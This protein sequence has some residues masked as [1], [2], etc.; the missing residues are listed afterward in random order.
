LVATLNMKN[1]YL[2]IAFLLFVACGRNQP[3]LTPEANKQQPTVAVGPEAI[4]DKPGAGESAGLT[5]ADLE[6]KVFQMG[7]ISLFTDSCAFYFACDCCAGD[8]VF[9]ADKTFYTINHCMSDKSLA[10][11]IYS[12]QNDKLT[13][14]FNG[15]CVSKNY[16]WANE[17]DTAAVDYFMTDTIV[18][19]W[20]FTYTATWCNNKIKLTRSDNK[21][22]GI[23]TKA[24]Y[25][26]YMDVLKKEGFA[27]RLKKIGNPASN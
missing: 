24:S 9:N 10:A 22:I 23:L 19:P 8:L 21:D 15:I 5:Y 7:S 18:S 11:G 2:L 17:T 6:G 12:L 16:N 14:S 25:A 1:L 3:A 20:L 4:A 26:N 13:L 27:E